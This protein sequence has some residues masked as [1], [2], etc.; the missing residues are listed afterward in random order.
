MSDLIYS[1]PSSSFSSFS[2]IFSLFSSPS[3]LSL[4]LFLL[5]SLLSLLIFLPFSPS[6]LPSHLPLPS[7]SYT[8][9]SPF[10]LFI[11]LP[12]LLLKHLSSTRNEALEI[13]LKVFEEN[14]E[15]DMMEFSHRLED[16]RCEITYPF[17]LLSPQ[18]AVHSKARG[19]VSGVWSPLE[20]V[21]TWI[22]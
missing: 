13:Q 3:T 1:L 2:L 18:S 12:P 4:P 16:I 7:L 10:F 17:L 8:L 22:L 5:V 21:F 19:T 9:P 20:T 11:L 6:A 15:E 14:K